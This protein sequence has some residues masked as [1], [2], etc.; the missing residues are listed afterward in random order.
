MTPILSRIFGR[1][2]QSVPLEQSEKSMKA[3]VNLLSK[4]DNQY[5]RTAAVI[6]QRQP[7]EQQFTIMRI[8][9]LLSR[10]NL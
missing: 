8:I 3:A 6:I 10:A 7:L 5:I 1:T 4:H 9:N 2:P